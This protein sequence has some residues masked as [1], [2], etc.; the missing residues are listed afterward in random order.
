MGRCLRAGLPR[1]WTVLSW[2]GEALLL[3]CCV[4]SVDQ[5]QQLTPEGANGGQLCAGAG[6]LVRPCWRRLLMVGWCVEAGDY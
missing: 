4:R 2:V 5:R 1:W 6:V 3:E